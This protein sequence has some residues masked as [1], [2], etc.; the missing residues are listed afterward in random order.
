[1]KTGVKTIRRPGNPHVPLRGGLWTRGRMIR[2]YASMR[3]AMS[4]FSVVVLILGVFMALGLGVRGFVS[5]SVFLLVSIPLALWAH[6]T[7]RGLR[8]EPRRL[9]ARRTWYALWRKAARG[10]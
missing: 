9:R 5:Q 1:M 10:N 4:L 3:R 8:R 6:F 2:R 7:V